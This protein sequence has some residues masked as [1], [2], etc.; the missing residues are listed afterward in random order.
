MRPAKLMTMIAEMTASRVPVAAKDASE[1][2]PSSS[3]T[4][5]LDRERCA[6]PGCSRDP[7]PPAFQAAIPPT[8][9]IHFRD[10]RVANVRGD[11]FIT[12][13]RC[14]AS[15][16]LPTADWSLRNIQIDDIAQQLSQQSLT[17]SSETAQQCHHRDDRR[18]E[19]TSRQVC[20]HL[21]PTWFATACIF[22]C[23]C[24]CC[25]TTIGF[26]CGRLVT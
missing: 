2:N 4:I 5:L 1:I 10:G 18:P 12:R 13:L 25:S 26:T 22:F 16:T 19:R 11:F 21:A 14:F 24:S 6:A 3:I 8:G 7:Q 17:Q 20:R 9:F 23:I 15:D